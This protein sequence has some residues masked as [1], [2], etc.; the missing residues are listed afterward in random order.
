MVAYLV[1]DV[2]IKEIKGFKEYAARIP[3]LIE[4]HGGRYLVKG[5]K[6]EVV[7]GKTGNPEYTVVIEF[8]SVDN[9]DAFLAERAQTD[10]VHIWGNS[11]DGRILK[12][13]GRC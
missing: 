4:K 11:T 13:E 1:V 6:P 12:V 5:V 2:N 10:L 3:T 8:P 9:A 7:Q